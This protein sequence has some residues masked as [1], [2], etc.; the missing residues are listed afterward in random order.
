MQFYLAQNIPTPK[1][2]TKVCPILTISFHHGISAHDVWLGDGSTVTLVRK[3]SARRIGLQLGCLRH[4]VY[5][6]FRIY[7]MFFFVSYTVRKLPKFREII[8]NFSM[9]IYTKFC[10]ILR[11]FV[12]CYTNFFND[13]EQATFSTH[14]RETSRRWLEV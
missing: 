1:W 12:T 14:S 3:E 13:L 4:F 11:N 6:K 7:R 9:Q 8:R 10:G 5:S 2:S